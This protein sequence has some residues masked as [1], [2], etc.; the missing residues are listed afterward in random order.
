MMDILVSDVNR[1]ASSI[2]QLTT[3]AGKLDLTMF[4][5]YP[6]VPT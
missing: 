3:E 1:N 5:K 2:S 6:C 4:L